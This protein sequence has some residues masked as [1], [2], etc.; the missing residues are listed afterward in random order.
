[1]LN[2]ILDLASNSTYDFRLTA[3]PADPLKYLF[4]EW[5]SYYRLKWAI[6]RT[7][8]PASILEVG[9]RFG[10]SAA[11]FLDAAPVSSTYLG[12]DN[13]SDTFGGKQ[14][15]INWAHAITPSSRAQFL[16]AD[17]SSMDRFPGGTYDLIHLDGQQDGV[18][19]IADLKKALRQAK[20]VL[21]DGY[22]WT[23]DNFL[24]MSEFLFRYRDL[25][26]SCII[27]PGYAG[28]LLI[29]P[30]LFTDVPAHA[31]NSSD[32][33]SAYD[34]SYYLRDCGGF[35]AFK[36]D[37]SGVP[38][39]ARLKSVADLVQIAPVGRALDLGSGRGELSIHLARQG[40]DVLSIDYSQAAVDLAMQAADAA[41]CN[42][43][44]EHYCGDVN[45]RPLSGKY[46][47]AVASDLIEHLAPEE[48]DRLYG[49]VALH[50]LPAG[51]FII[52][53]FPNL[54]YYKYDYPRR[55]RQARALGA[56]LPSEPR[57]RY[58]ELMHINEQSPRRLR[59]QLKAHFDHVLIWFAHHGLGNPFDNLARRFSR[60]EIRAAGDLFAI[61]SH[62]PIE[63]DALRARLQMRPVAMAPCVEIRI[64]DIPETVEAGEKFNA[65]VRLGNIGDTDLKSRPP[66]PVH[67]AYH[68]YSSDNET[69]VFDSMRTPI[70]TLRAGASV[71]SLMYLQA[72]GT[73]GV[74]R[75]RLTLVQESVAWFDTP[76]HN[77][78]E[79]K[80]LLVV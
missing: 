32:L 73:K 50:L 37:A 77:A 5:V 72:P 68:C 39:D 16:I 80:L 38:L 56:Y 3:N 53:T 74:V 1:M 70:P 14:G 63:I 9:V 76:P 25:I 28:E 4:A 69:L 41:K 20:Y 13:D 64:V 65:R 42:G 60:A 55:A 49:Q 11:A 45:S 54:W 8:Q 34:K 44:I 52:H 66:N 67:L 18:C 19:S 22:F 23:R 31:E 7:L 71:E 21:V 48:L 51:V 78:F 17:S 57:S 62:S 2:R 26:E 6:A 79:D 59:S 61:A 24:H 75:F 33:R 12:I 27:I 46:S 10:Y 30:A 43:N 29:T 15:A 58:E 35:D 47:L 36:R 40:F